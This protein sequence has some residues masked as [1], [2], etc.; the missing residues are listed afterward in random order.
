MHPAEIHARENLL[1]LRPFRN[2]SNSM[3][4]PESPACRHHACSACHFHQDAESMANAQTVVLQL[5]IQTICKASHAAELTR[6][7]LHHE[8]RAWSSSGNHPPRLQGGTSA[9]HRI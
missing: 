7:I 3:E 2:A 6:A 4:T 8:S 9:C 5:P 1:T